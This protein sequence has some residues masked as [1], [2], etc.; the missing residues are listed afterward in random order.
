VEDCQ[1]SYRRKDHLNR[2]LLQH[3]GKLFECPVD[4]CKSRFTVKGNIKRHLVEFH[5]DKDPDLVDSPSAAADGQKQCVCPESGCGKVFKYASYL[6]K[7]EDS[8]VK[9]DTV[10][11]FCSEPGCMK[12]FTNEQYLR[13]HLQA[14]HQYINCEICG[15][16]YL[17]KNIKRHLRTHDPA[18]SEESEKKIECTYKGCSH[19]FSTNSNLRQHIK[20]IHFEDKPF[21]C[22]LP[23]CDMRFSFKHVRDNHEK[24][25]C[26]V[27][28][29]GDFLETD[30]Q[31]QSIPRGGRKRT[32]PSID[33]LTRK[34]IVPPSVSDSVLNESS[35]FLSW[36]QNDD[37]S[38]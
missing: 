33:T 32:C 23:G 16:K 15:I 24:S 29:P 28:T 4:D 30:E 14:C 1:S 9:L 17:K 8:H 31:F 35:D 6:R 38:R 18:P 21:A 13:D 20:A 19:T 34:R 10:E 7:H 2:H 3:K 22:S 25:A 5:N 26:H 12:Y 27:Y 11:V 37:G 36:L